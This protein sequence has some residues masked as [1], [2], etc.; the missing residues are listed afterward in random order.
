MKSAAARPTSLTPPAPAPTTDLH[1]PPTA[2]THH[3]AM[4]TPELE[5]HLSETAPLT[6]LLG[7]GKKNDPLPLFRICEK[8][9][10]LMLKR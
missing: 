6:T 1:T 9:C 10:K 8:I 7:L 5:G 4:E 3:R 2:P